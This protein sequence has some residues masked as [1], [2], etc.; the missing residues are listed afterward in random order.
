[1]NL[2][3]MIAGYQS[4]GQEPD[5]QPMPYVPGGPTARTPPPSPSGP[6]IIDLLTAA[7]QPKQ[8]TIPAPNTAGILPMALLRF[9]A[10]VTAPK[11]YGQS[12][13]NA[14]LSSGSHALEYAD[15]L[16]G[17]AAASAE[18]TALAQGKLDESA[19]R[20]A[21]SRVGTLANAQKVKQ[22]AERAP[23][24][25]EKLRAAIENSKGDTE[26]NGIKIRIA[27]VQERYAAQLEEAKLA[28]K[29]ARTNSERAQAA[30]MGEHARLYKRQADELL[31]EID[32]K[33]RTAG[34]EWVNMPSDIPG[35][36]PTAFNRVTNERK[37]GRFSD[38]QSALE[39]AKREVDAM[40]KAGMLKGK[41]R[42]AEI[43]RLINEA[44]PEAG[45]AA[46]GRVVPASTQGGSSAPASAST[47]APKALAPADQ[48]GY[49][50]AMRLAAERKNGQKFISS[51]GDV[52]Y[53]W[54]G[55]EVS[56]DE[57]QRITGKR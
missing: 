29:N 5:A 3:D 47:P 55:R 56:G 36:R 8:A 57:F 16:K 24:E 43:Q 50:K 2:L 40:D 4:A 37:L 19:A 7:A 38:V 23:L 52:H 17:E 35:G 54:A 46:S 42:Q 45:N 20:T 15:K 1:M 39:W 13:A 12:S 30:M 11:R 44:G 41:D 48:E 33:R 28:E 25:L 26:L 9:A 34:M 18:R 6:N 51:S 31:N 14:I 32:A 27:K 10:E 22:D 21:E 53:F 49:N